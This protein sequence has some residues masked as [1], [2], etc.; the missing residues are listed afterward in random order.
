MLTHPQFNPVALSLG[1]ISIHWYGLMYLVAFVLFVMLGRLHARRRPELGWDAGKIDDLLLYGMLGVVIGGRLGEVVFFQLPYYLSNPLEIIA[2]W[3]GGMSFHG[4]FLGVL[5]AMALYARRQGRSFWE[6][7]DF[8]APLVPT[9]LAAGRIGNFINGELWGRPVASDIP[10]AMIFPFVDQIP[11]HPSQFYQAAGEG[12]LLFALLWWYAARPR[13]LK[14]V[15]AVFLVGYGSLRFVA[16]FF[17]TPD[18]G[19]FG[20]LSLGLS[21]AQWL[22]VPMVGLGIMLLVMQPGKR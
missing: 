2:I 11:R 22:C 7:T 19:I 12:L 4:G 20:T 10:W 9:G 15:S 13:P 8:I 21:T 14:A 16:E 3:K 18:P 5:V 17:R 6:V 1:P